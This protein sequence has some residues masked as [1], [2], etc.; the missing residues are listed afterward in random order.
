MPWSYRKK[1]KIAPDI[2]LNVIKKGTSASFGMR[3]ASTNAEKN[4]IYLNTGVPGTGIYK[5]KKINDGIIKDASSVAFTNTKANADEA[6]A[7]CLIS[8]S[9]AAII[10]LFF[11]N[12]FVGLIGLSIFCIVIAITSYSAEKKVKKFVQSKIRLAKTAIEQTTNPIQKIILQSFVSCVELSKKA[13]EKEAIINA[14]QKKLEKKENIKLREQLTKYETELSNL[15]EE[16]EKIQFDA[17]KNLSDIEKQQFLNLCNSFENL[18]ECQKIWIIKSSNKY[19]KTPAST[20][21]NRKAITFDTGVFNYIKSD[22]DIPML[23]DSAGI[24]YYIYPQFI[25]KAISF[26]IQNYP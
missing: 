22:F 9:L 24:I 16:L 2:S 19:A 11:L 7:G 8:L 23:R 15:Y 1:I 14:L 13:D 26:Y 10:G 18:L 12:I 25:I 4:G 6:K 17:D 5:R 3:G 20:S 21:I